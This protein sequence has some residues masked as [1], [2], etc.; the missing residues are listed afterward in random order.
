M[1]RSRKTID[2]DNSYD[3]VDEADDLDSRKPRVGIDVSIINIK[4][5]AGRIALISN[6]FQYHT[7]I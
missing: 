6:L 5:Y 1:M 2:E 4:Q 3:N 7:R